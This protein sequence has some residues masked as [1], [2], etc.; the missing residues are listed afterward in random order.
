[1]LSPT[2]CSTD[3]QLHTHTVIYGGKVSIN[4]QAALCTDLCLNLEERK[5]VERKKLGL[6]VREHRTS[7]VHEDFSSSKDKKGDLLGGTVM[8]LAIQ[9]HSKQKAAQ[10][11]A[12]THV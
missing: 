8:I 5:A 6:N 7:P 9:V 11:E 1:M 10:F 2:A 12:T 4:K 3:G